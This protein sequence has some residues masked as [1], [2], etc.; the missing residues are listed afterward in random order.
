MKNKIITLTKV[1][2]KNSF[3]KNSL[4]KNKKG[5]VV[6]YI[7]LAI[8]LAGLFGFSAYNLIVPLK[9]IN[10]EALF[11]SLFVITLSAFTLFQSIFTSLN[12]FYYS[13]DIEY[14]LPLPVKPYQILMAKFN[15]IL[16]TEYITNF[17]FGI[18]V[19]AVYGY[20]AQ[21]GILFYIAA[22]LFLLLLPIIPLLIASLIIM[23]IMSFSKV[24]KNKDKFQVLASVIA[25]II[26]LGLQFA[27]SRNR[28]NNSENN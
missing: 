18:P 24:T 14:I 8:Y 12:V 21:M 19:I 9:S 7:F 10:Q 22:I 16:I 4:S 13:K 11:L 15:V 1:I 25:I 28:R 23:I 17:I 3:N 6:G 20:V 2:L 5:N 27:I 26:V